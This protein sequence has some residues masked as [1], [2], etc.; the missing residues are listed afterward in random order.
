MTVELIQAT[1]RLESDS[2][3]FGQGGR[4]SLDAGYPP[5]LDHPEAEITKTRKQTPDQYLLLFMMTPLVHDS[6]RSVQQSWAVFAGSLEIVRK[7]PYL[8]ALIS[9]PLPNISHQDGSLSR[10]VTT[11]GLLNIN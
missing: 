9:H 4:H 6:L 8:P 10:Q 3:Q 11:P 5:S 7:I 2:S 1:Q